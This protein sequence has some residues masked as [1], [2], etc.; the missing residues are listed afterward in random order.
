MAA[1][2]IIV[3]IFQVYSQLSQKDGVR[4]WYIDFLVKDLNS[5]VMKWTSE[6]STD[7]NLFSRNLDR[8]ERTSRWITDST[9]LLCLALDQFSFVQN[10]A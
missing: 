7:L 2:I 3:L 4:N 5:D 1:Q 9:S 6:T 8:L 10:F